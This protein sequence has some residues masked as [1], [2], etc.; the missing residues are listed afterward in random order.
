MDKL[1]S[2][3]DV[4]YE[5][6]GVT[7]RRARGRDQGNTETGVS[8]CCCQQRVWGWETGNDRAYT[9]RWWCSGRKLV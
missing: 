7:K 8:Y 2:L 9:G 4:Q 6:N 3:I 1:E 5:V